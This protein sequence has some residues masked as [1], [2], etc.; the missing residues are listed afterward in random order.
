MLEPI[1][2]LHDK[3]NLKGPHDIEIQG[4]LAFVAGKWGAFSIVDVAD[5]V[6]PEILGVITEG[7]VNPET[8][9]PAGEICFFGDR[10]FLRH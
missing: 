7:M 5:P 4:D 8:V 3:E 2:L 10:G 1:A 9:L 6:R